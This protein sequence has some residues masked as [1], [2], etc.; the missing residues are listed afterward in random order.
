[1]LAGDQPSGACLCM[2]S[3]VRASATSPPSVRLQKHCEPP[4]GWHSGC[5]SPSR[6]GTADS[7]EQQFEGLC[8]GAGLQQ[9]SSRVTLLSVCTGLSER[10]GAR[11]A[12]L[13]PW[14]QR[15]CN[16]LDYRRPADTRPCCLPDSSVTHYVVLPGGASVPGA[17][18]ALTRVPRQVRGRLSARI[19]GSYARSTGPVVGSA[20][21]RSSLR[22]RPERSRAR[23]SNGVDSPGGRCQGPLAPSCSLR[24]CLKTSSLTCCSLSLPCR[25]TGR[26]SAASAGHG[27][28]HPGP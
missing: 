14:R 23:C 3:I 7:L 22:L 26:A 12:C 9:P 15:W 19:A 5:G 27:R 18:A 11:R 1:M 6:P 16:S 10:C 21:R 8:V 2:H 13:A 20:V 28:C 17:S 25:S 24:S 4:P